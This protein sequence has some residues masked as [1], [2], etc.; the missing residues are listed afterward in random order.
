MLCATEKVGEHNGNG[1]IKSERS[2]KGTART[3][4]HKVFSQK[5]LLFKCCALL[6]WLSILQMMSS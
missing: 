2:D 5:K 3:R 4:T 6:N 1:K